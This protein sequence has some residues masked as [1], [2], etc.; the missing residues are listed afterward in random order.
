[1]VY[2]HAVHDYHENERDNEKDDIEENGE[3]LLQGIVWPD[4]TTFTSS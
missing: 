1:M 2:N 3:G 4:F